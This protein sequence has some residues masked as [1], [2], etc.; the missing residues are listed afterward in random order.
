MDDPRLMGMGET[1]QNLDDDR[2]LAFERHRPHAQGLLEVLAAEQLHRHVRRTVGVIPEV[3]HVDHVGMREAGDRLRLALEAHLQ[4]RVVGD[5]RHHDLEGDLA[6]EHRVL[7]EVHDAHG[8]LAEGLDDVVL[9]DPP[10][11]LLESRFST[12]CVLFLVL[13]TGALKA[14]LVIWPRPCR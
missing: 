14:A 7:R 10:R 8:A 11:Y 1:D 12:H 9:A 13:S 2:D 6:V 5:V 4:L 3:E